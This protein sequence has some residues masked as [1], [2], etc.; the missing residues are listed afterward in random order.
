MLTAAGN[1][2]PVAVGAF[3]GEVTTRHEPNA[4]SRE[5]L[6]RVVSY[7]VL[8]HFI[9]S[10]YRPGFCVRRLGSAVLDLTSFH[11]DHLLIRLRWTAGFLRPR[12]CADLR[13]ERHIRGIQCAICPGSNRRRKENSR[14]LAKS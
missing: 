13:S 1:I 2:A 12:E 4:S 5:T 14:R 3:A 10:L 9:S 7:V 6:H 8:H 11:T